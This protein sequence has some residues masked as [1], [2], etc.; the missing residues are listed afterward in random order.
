MIEIDWAAQAVHLRNTAT[1]EADWNETVAVSLV[2]STDQ[3][4]VDVGCGGGGMAM[5]LAGALPTV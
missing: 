4:A 3:L 2:R 5:A 1:D